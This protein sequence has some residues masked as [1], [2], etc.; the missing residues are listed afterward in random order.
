M[1]SPLHCCGLGS[2]AAQVNAL[3][4]IWAVPAL[5]ATL[6]AFHPQPDISHNALVAQNAIKTGKQ[7][8]QRRKNRILFLICRVFATAM[9]TSRKPEFFSGSRETQLPAAKW[10]FSFYSK[11][12]ILTKNS[13]SPFSLS[14]TQ[15]R[16][17]GK[18]SYF[19]L[20]LSCAVFLSQLTDGTFCCRNSEGCSSDLTCLQKTK[21]S[22]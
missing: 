7:S 13:P 8:N 5:T 20:H 21:I 2:I 9:K 16:E 12:G 17:K 6:P 19:N 18:K 1:C 4:P 3:T 14:H 11:L 15:K 22:K 10:K